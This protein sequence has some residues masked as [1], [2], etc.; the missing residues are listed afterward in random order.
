MKC[1]HLDFDEYF[2]QCVDCKATREEVLAGE[3]KNE[4]QAVYGKMLDSVGLETGDIAPDQL[5]ALETAENAL[6]S[7]VAGWINSSYEEENE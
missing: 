7:V 4:L 6:A 2:G 1:E 3:F 5:V